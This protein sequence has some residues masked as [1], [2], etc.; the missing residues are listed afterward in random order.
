M[1]NATLQIHAA[2]RSNL[3]SLIGVHISLLDG[4]NNSDRA[5]SEQLAYNNYLVSLAA[6]KAAG[7]LAGDED[8]EWEK[9]YR[10][11]LSRGYTDETTCDDC[12][13]TIPTD[14][15]TIMG[16]CDLTLCRGCKDCTCGPQLTH[17]K[18]DEISDGFGDFEDAPAF[19]R[20]MPVELD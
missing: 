4:V 2:A 10:L 19:Q 6:Y 3:T 18:A 5:S 15:A 13:A 12:G 1:Q 9:E 7:I 14:L 11:S 16:D 20:G 17:A 8:R